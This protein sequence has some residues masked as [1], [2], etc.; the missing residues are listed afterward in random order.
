M[1]RTTT[2]VRVPAMPAVFLPLAVSSFTVRQTSQPQYTKMDS[3]MPAAI[4]PKVSILVTSNHSQLNG[5]EVSEEDQLAKAMAT[6]SPSTS[7]WKPTR[8]YW[9]ILVVCRPR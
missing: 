3:E 7:S 2:A 4:W 8:P 6:N 5:M 9:T 1:P